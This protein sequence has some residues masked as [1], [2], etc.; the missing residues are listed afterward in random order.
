MIFWMI[1]L[2]WFM[3]VLRIFFFFLVFGVVFEKKCNKGTIFYIGYLNICHTTAGFLKLICYFSMLYSTYGHF[4]L[5]QKHWILSL[6]T[7]V[8]VHELL[9]FFN[10]EYL[11]ESS[12]IM[13]TWTFFS[14]YLFSLFVNFLF[15]E[16][17]L[18]V[19]QAFGG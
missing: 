15:T 4:F 3:L 6:F 17:S 8:L 14:T 10:N 16:W 12:S 2:C 9:E 19:L 11:K 18:A 1:C 7:L 5:T 13:N